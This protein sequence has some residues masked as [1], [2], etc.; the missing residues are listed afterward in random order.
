MR[1]MTVL[2]PQST[3]FS[4]RMMFLRACSLSS[5]ATASSQSRKITSAADF[6]AFS[7]SPG[8]DPGTASSER[9]RRGVACTTLVKLMDSPR[10]AKAAG[11]AIDRQQQWRFIGL[12]FAP[13]R[14]RAIAAQ[15]LDLLPVCVRDARELTRQAAPKLRETRS[16]LR[17]G[18]HL[19]QHFRGQAE[20]SLERIEDARTYRLVGHKLRIFA[21]DVEVDLQQ[22]L[23]RF[24]DDQP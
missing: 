1:T 22:S 11:D 9:C 12:F 3:S 24:I 19:E 5:G 21:R 18:T 8:L 17:T 14:R 23:L 4:P 2:A 6:A 7:N 15:Q 10:A 16:D 20:F 13:V